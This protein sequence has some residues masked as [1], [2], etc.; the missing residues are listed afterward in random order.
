MREASARRHAQVILKPNESG[1][2]ILGKIIR[3]NPL[4]LSP[5]FVCAEV[6]FGYAI[7]LVPDL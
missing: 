7:H 4:E 5:A 1:V 6:M 2:T 3:E